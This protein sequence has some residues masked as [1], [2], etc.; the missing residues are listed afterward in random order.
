MKDLL[1]KNLGLKIFSLLFSMVLWFYIT[2]EKESE[3]GFLVKLSVRNIPKDMELVGKRVDRV[4]VWVYG[5]RRYLM[6]ISPDEI[7]VPVD[8]KNAKEGVIIYPINLE[9]I[10]VPPEV[11]VTRVSP[12]TIRFQLERVIGKKVKVV[13]ELKGKLAL[14]Y[15]IESMDEQPDFVNVKGKRSIIE[16]L[17]TVYTYPIDINGLS[18]NLKFEVPI[19]E[20]R[21]KI[22][23]EEGEKM[24]R[25]D[26]KV[27]E[28][29]IEKTFTEV[30]VSVEDLDQS[31]IAV[32]TPDKATLKL[33]GPEAVLVN[34][35]NKGENIKV[36]LDIKKLNSNK[37][38]RRK[39]KVILPDKIILLKL[40]P[41]WFKI[42]VEEE[43]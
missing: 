17:N 23:V 19:D 36:V 18:Q 16:N 4:T 30:P 37:T 38:V 11:S 25:V 21:S 6:R 2:T 3:L 9:V 1:F 29:I 28:R 22:K 43:E 35:N 39:A 33:K 20:E 31:T 41:E 27:K 32:I 15:D 13:P 14:G 24:V 5:L 42:H 40:E 10:K 26:I 12:S 34:L 8:L 7:V